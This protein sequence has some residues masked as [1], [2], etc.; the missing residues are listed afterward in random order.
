M[1]WMCA[2]L[3]VSN[4]SLSGYA[5]A[6]YASSFCFCRHLWHRMLLCFNQSLL[7]VAVCVYVTAMECMHKKIC[8]TT[9]S[10]CPVC[11]KDVVNCGTQD[12]HR[13]PRVLLIHNL[14][15]AAILWHA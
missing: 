5:G 15:V 11:H 7:V 9:P 10:L 12:V 4:S 6:G 2:R 8:V 1:V 3:T 13:L 14:P